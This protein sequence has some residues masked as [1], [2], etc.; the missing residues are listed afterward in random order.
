[1]SV[2]RL[3][4]NTWR[5]ILTTQ[6]VARRRPHR[7]HQRSLLSLLLFC[8]VKRGTNVDPLKLAVDIQSSQ[9]IEIIHYNR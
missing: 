3:C 1:M 6:N 9:G 2:I 7:S 4:A 8:A 5:Q